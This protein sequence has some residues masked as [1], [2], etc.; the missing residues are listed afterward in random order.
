M[1]ELWQAK[2]D[3]SKKQ[4]QIME[5]SARKLKEK[6]E[7]TEQSSKKQQ[8]VMNELT[9]KQE[10]EG[11]KDQEAKEA[12]DQQN[13]NQVD[14]MTKLTE[15]NAK[16]GIDK[17]KMHDDIDKLK[18]YILTCEINVVHIMMS[19][20]VGNINSIS[21]VEL[22]RMRVEDVDAEGGNDMHRFTKGVKSIIETK[23]NIAKCLHLF[24]EQNH[25]HESTLNRISML[26]PVLGVIADDDKQ[27]LWDA[28]YAEWVGDEKDQPGLNDVTDVNMV[29]RL[30]IQGIL[31][32]ED[33]QAISQNN[34]DTN[35]GL[36]EQFLLSSKKHARL[37]SKT[38]FDTLK[39]VKSTVH[40]MHLSFPPST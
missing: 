26:L 15:E 7:H 6:L 40:A 17:K 20:M 28:I 32:V 14:T 22:I 30:V 33:V 39:E 13:R 36:R 2:I 34:F 16:I 35:L 3:E 10:E 19:Y 31:G 25:H 1:V 12:K 23:E 27:N 5:D 9:K 8:D 4:S 38:L 29:T 24:F 18:Q 11:K 21:E 37:V